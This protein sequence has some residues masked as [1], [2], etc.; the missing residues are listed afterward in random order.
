MKP[1]YITMCAFG[2]YGGEVKV[3]LDKLGGT[4]LFLITGD[5]GAGKT[6]VFDAI[7]FALY[8]EVSGSART[9]DTVRSDFAEDNTKTY[10][11][12]E[13]LQKE[14]RYHIKRNPKYLRPK[15]NGTGMTTETAD[16]T[17]TMADGSVIT[18]YRTAT[19]KIEE[20]LGID[21]R[22]FKQI[23]MIAQGE[24]LKLLLADSST[25][26]NIFRKVFHTDM[27]LN[28][29]TILKQRELEL[30]SCCDMSQNSV[31]QYLN[32]IICPEGHLLYDEFK[33]IDCKNIFQTS[34]CLEILSRLIETDK[35][36]WQRE[37]QELNRLEEGLE[38]LTKAI[39]NANHYFE[40]KQK[41][42]VAKKEESVLLLQKPEMEQAKAELEI[43]KKALH[44]IYPLERAYIREKEATNVLIQNIEQLKQ[45]IATEEVQVYTREKELNQA[46]SSVPKINELIDKISKQKEQLTLYGSL[47][48]EE[49]VLDSLEKQGK[50]IEELLVKAEAE[51]NKL[52]I[53]MEEKEKELE[54]LE[55]VEANLLFVTNQV[56]AATSLDTQIKDLWQ[57]YKDLCKAKQAFLLQQS[58]YKQTEIAYKKVKYEFD[59]AERRFF[60]E[61][62]GIL[63]EFLQDN[64]PCPVCG[65]LHH[66]KKATFSG[67][68]P[69]EMQLTE[70]RKQKE[71]EMDRWQTLSSLCGNEKTRLETWFF[72]LKKRLK[73]VSIR[74]EDTSPKEY[75]LLF[76]EEQKKIQGEKNVAETERI[77]LEQQSLKKKAISKELASLKE[78]KKEN[79]VTLE[80]KNIE[81][82]NVYAKISGRKGKIEAMKSNLQYTSKKVAEGALQ[83]M[84]EEK[85]GLARV[86]EDAERIYGEISTSLQSH[87]AVYSDKNEDLSDRKEQT[88]VAQEK[89]QEA[90]RRFGFMDEAS[91]QVVLKPEEYLEKMEKE[92]DEFKI[93]YQRIGH[94]IEQLYRDMKEMKS[95]DPKE[96]SEKKEQIFKQKKV[97]EE[98][99]QNIWA[100]LNNNETIWKN[101]E[102]ENKQRQELEKEYLVFKELSK[103]ANGE[104]QGKQKLAFEQYIQAFYFNRIIAEANKRLSIMTGGRFE[105]IREEESDNLRS[106]TG[107]ELGIID[108]YTGKSRS[109]KSLSGG[110]SF[111]AS[112]ALA[113]GLSDVIQTHAGGVEID[114]MFIDEG[115]GALDEESL[116]QAIQILSGLAHGNRLVGIVSHVT[117]LKERIEKK[118]I[119]KKGR[120]GSSIEIV[121]S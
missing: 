5:T 116:E 92:I 112:L 42:E 79:E 54:S 106:Q 16:A 20:L 37:K 76:A 13:F 41:L 85:D 48:E 58:Q 9:T 1:M 11:E 103:T 75:D 71:K 111:K 45:T 55:D 101:T 105:L 59:E 78:N 61:Q 119:V 33:S 51:K 114:T 94:T 19:E 2:P 21:A 89:Y 26:G 63:A 57:E 67:K 3:S 66:P 62:A 91:Y 117:E 8:G 84:Q 77:R 82:N 109:V 95:E 87:K 98:Q 14:K 44:H 27:Y 86:L 50:E 31:K 23:A 46:K 102:K 49:K 43:Q 30:K 4:G 110:E 28:L 34:Q 65:S 74:F 56:D 113:L 10:V 15:K 81:R 32:G 70:L 36:D 24:F 7:C 52:S 6:T 121:E 108:Y 53:S 29:Q 18:G 99:L 97:K 60:R 38:Q 39:T 69:T 22:Q 12:L 72:E 115:F 80:N 40:L 64:E 104:L 73:D 120:K 88:T 118:I 100:R 83:K 107:L 17:L 96:L 90:L 47:E 93:T 35:G 68:A 25:R